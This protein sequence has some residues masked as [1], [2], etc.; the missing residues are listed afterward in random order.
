MAG[1]NPDPIGSARARG[2]EGT[3]EALEALTKIYSDAAR[4]RLAKLDTALTSG[5]A[6]ISA[7]PGEAGVNAAGM[8][9]KGKSS[10]IIAREG[11]N[12]AGMPIKP[13]ASPIIAREDRNAQVAFSAIAGIGQL[14]PGE[15]ECLAG[16]GINVGMHKGI[17]SITRAYVPAA[18]NL[19]QQFR[20][21]RS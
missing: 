5:I 21:G 9:T 3:V 7:A 13:Q 11:V 14:R 12:A 17:L 19:L 20:G 4:D 15:V 6:K 2:H 8:P 16:H 18:T 1:R 10:P